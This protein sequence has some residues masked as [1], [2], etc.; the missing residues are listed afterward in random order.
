MGNIFN[1]GTRT[2]NI[3]SSKNEKCIMNIYS[4]D[5]KLIYNSNININE[6][7]NTVDLNSSLANGTYIVRLISNNNVAVKKFAIVK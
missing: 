2:I 7:I 5:G 6:G 3:V 1:L 4:I